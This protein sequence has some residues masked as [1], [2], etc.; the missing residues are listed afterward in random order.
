MIA[1]IALWQLGDTLIDL[2]ELRERMREE[3][4]PTYAATPGLAFAAFV[5]DELGDRWGVVSLWEDE[6]G[7]I[8]GA[9]IIGK[10]PDVDDELAVEASVSGDYDEHRLAG[11]GR[12]AGGQELL[13][14]YLWRLDGETRVSLPDLRT[15]IEE[16]ALDAFAGV[17]GLRL[18]AWVS[19]E[20]VAGNEPGAARYGA[21]CFWETPDAAL[22]PSPSRTAELVGRG[23]DVVEE[24]D[25][26]ATVVGTDA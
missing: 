8:P 7:A 14:L 24:F 6:P 19:D 10:D 3:W 16:E 25:V 15:H 9:D 21:F 5:S 1:R 22:A 2:G 13:R 20:T 11:R 4:L 23:P 26:E 12:E 17:A 18:K